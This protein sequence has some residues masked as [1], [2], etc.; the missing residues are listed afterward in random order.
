M[1]SPR[2]FVLTKRLRLRSCSA[3]NGR[4]PLVPQ[5]SRYSSPDRRVLLSSDWS[6]AGPE[7]GESL[8]TLSRPLP[9]VPFVTIAKVEVRSPKVPRQRERRSK[10]FRRLRSLVPRPA[11]LG[12]DEQFFPFRSMQSTSSSLPEL[13]RR[14]DF[15]GWRWVPRSREPYGY[16]DL[17]RH[18]SDVR[19]AT[20][21]VCVQASSGSSAS[22]VPGTDST[23]RQPLSPVSRM[24]GRLVPL[25]FV[26]VLA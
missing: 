13:W 22:G 19:R 12:L 25:A 2:S 3:V 6:M 9:D 21:E 4:C 20:S 10:R 16:C 14:G 17:V 26:S 11:F 7:R 5:R 23:S 1:S 15:L 24:P 18:P 8:H